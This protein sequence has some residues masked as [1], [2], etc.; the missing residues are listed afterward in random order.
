MKNKFNSFTYNEEEIVPQL[1]SDYRLSA[2]SRVNAIHIYSE[3]LN[4]R[5]LIPA[6]TFYDSCEEKD[7]SIKGNIIQGSFI[8]GKNKEIYTEEEYFEW[9]DAIE[10]NSNKEIKKKDLIPGELCILDNG[11]KYFF[12]GTKYVSKYKENCFYEI[13]DFL[14]DMDITKINK[15][16]YFIKENELPNET[17]KFDMSVAYRTRGIHTPSLNFLKDAISD[18]LKNKIIGID[19]NTLSKKE[20]SE[21]LMLIYMDNKN[22]AFFEDFKEEN[23]NYIW[24]NRDKRIL[25]V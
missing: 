18:N 4:Q 2:S 12:L 11:E 1:A 22:I 25:N 9:Q 15:K 7:I 8:F 17:D 10:M 3:S 5:F 19:K 20:T 13:M 21:L 23:P 14:Y 24:S 6:A 16:Y